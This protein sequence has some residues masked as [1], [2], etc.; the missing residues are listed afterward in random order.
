MKTM[1]D[2]WVAF[3]KVYV[4][5]E[6]LFQSARAP[7]CRW[8]PAVWSR[9]RPQENSERENSLWTG[10]LPLFSVVMTLPTFLNSTHIFKSCYGSSTGLFSL[11]DC[12]GNHP[13][14]F[15]CLCSTPR[16]FNVL[17]DIQLHHAKMCSYSFLFEVWLF[18]K[19]VSPSSRSKCWKNYRWR[20]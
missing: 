18:T 6:I 5:P 19:E 1:W 4:W 20:G 14:R 7:I 17:P 9:P 12:I 15:V 16:I 2:E 3:S 10:C 8:I 13:N 11:L